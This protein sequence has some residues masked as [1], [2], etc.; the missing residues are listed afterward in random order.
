MDV[1]GIKNHHILYSG[2]R[3]RAPYFTLINGQLTLKMAV[4]PIS[5][6]YNYG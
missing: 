3:S 2:S 6:V 4:E 1:I 5:E